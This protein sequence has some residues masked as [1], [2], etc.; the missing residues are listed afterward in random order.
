MSTSEHY[1]HP[2]A[3]RDNVF[4]DKVPSNYRVV[5]DKVPYK[6]SYSHQPQQDRNIMSLDLEEP[7]PTAPP[8]RE[9]CRVIK[10]LVQEYF[11]L[12]L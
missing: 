3:T 9:I 5:K 12:N 4:G 10:F 8:R 2:R 1:A 6:K 11:I 7:P